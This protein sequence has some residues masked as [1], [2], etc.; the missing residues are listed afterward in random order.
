MNTNFKFLMVLGFI[1]IISGLSTFSQVSINANGDPPDNS[2][3]LD[4]NSTSK[5]ILVPRMTLIQRNAI[6]TPATGLMIYQTDNITGFYCNSGTSAAPVW[7]LVGGNAG[8]WLISGTNIYYTTGNVGIGTNSP[9]AMLQTV[10]TGTGQ[11]NVVFVGEYKPLNPGDP[12]VSGAGT[13]MMWY[14]DKASFRA[15]YV[16][17]EQWN[18]GNVGDFSAA[19]NYKTTASGSNS[20]ALGYETKATGDRSI[21]MGHFTTAS[22]FGSMTAGAFTTAPSTCE[23]AVGINNTIYSPL[24][25]P[26]GWNANDRLFV[27]GN[28]WLSAHNALTVLKNGNIGIGTDTPAELLDVNGNAAFRAIGSGAYEGP[29]NR[30][31][32]GTLTTATSDERLKEN[33][34][35]LQDCLFKVLQ[36]RGVS[37]TWKTNPEYG[38]RIGFIAQEF[39]KIIPELVFTNKRDGYK[40]INYAEVSSV[41]VEAIKE[42]KAENDLLKAENMQ[43]K[44]KIETMESRLSKLESMIEITSHK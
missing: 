29:V 5:G 27:I 1:L 7:T 28:G 9:S 25:T 30:T 2:A 40:G 6:I 31:S 26:G 38:M 35:T 19:L 10:G 43:L 11:G 4:I 41:L 13:R 22:G 14:P 8:Q 20:T 34:S 33:I 23:M 3:M 36:L 12:P 16:D 18:V 44:T 39:E 42:L 17:G 21:S 24:G 37:Y 15:G 32:D